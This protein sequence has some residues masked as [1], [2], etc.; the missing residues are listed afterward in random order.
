MKSNHALRLVTLAGLGSLMAA[1]AFA[2]DSYYYGGLSV[3]TSRAKLNE[4][5]ITASQLPAGVTA[6]SIRSDDRETGFKVFGGYQANRY[7]GFEA[8][9]FSLG[10][11]TYEG[12]TNPAGIINGKLNFKGLNAD[13]VGTMPITDNFSVLGRVGA[14]FTRTRSAFSGTGA[15]NP[16]TDPGPNK[17]ETNYKVGA[18]VQ[19]AFSPSVL[20]RAEVERYRVNEAVGGHGVVNTVTVGLVFPFG[21]SAPMMKT[22]MATPYV[23]PAPAP[24]PIVK[25][26]PAPA[27]VVVQAPPP[28]PVVVVVAAPPAPV[29]PPR[30]RVTYSAESMF[31]FDKSA[32]QP[33]GMAAL[34]TFSKE[35]Q[36]TRF[37]KV[38]V[39]GYTDR[40]G[41]S[42]YNQKLSME[43]A[44]AVKAY[45]VSKGGVDAAKVTAAGMGEGNP[46]TKPEDCKGIKATAKLRACLQ[47]DRR[48]EI[49]VTGTK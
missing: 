39:E 17:R 44:E 36:G 42:E 49:E 13:I 48:V 45:L 47:P 34:D 1:S 11:F 6:T 23:A 18:G 15:A 20:G 35:L 3:G 27:P 9:Y 28:A 8:G 24:A 38:S 29:I 41:S 5:R 46:A 22:A 19:Y 32:V 21:R 31:G 25:V 12:I 43:R 2:Q 4:E 33:E 16:V 37:D 7:I 40:L 30:T 14:Q 26:E 10:K